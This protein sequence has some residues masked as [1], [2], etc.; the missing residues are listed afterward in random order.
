VCLIN[1]EG[2][3]IFLIQ[4]HWLDRQFQGVVPINE[5]G[6]DIDTYKDWKRVM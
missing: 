3:T 2:K 6:R 5:E 1:L 4:F